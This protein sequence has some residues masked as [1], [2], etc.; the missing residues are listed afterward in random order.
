M[1]SPLVFGAGEPSHAEDDQF[2]IA[3]G[4]S[5]LAQNVAGKNQPS[6]HELRM[7]GQRGEEVEDLPIHSHAFQHLLRFR[8]QLGGSELLYSWLAKTHV[9]SP[10]LFSVAMLCILVCEPKCVTYCTEQMR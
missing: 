8:V 5:R 7:M 3:L 4:K 6:L 9:S 2:A 1:V 10:Y